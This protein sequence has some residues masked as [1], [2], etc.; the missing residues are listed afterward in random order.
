V[1]LVRSLPQIALLHRREDQSV[2]EN[3]N[4]LP[5]SE[6]ALT[7]RA[8]VMEGR[9]P[10]GDFAAGI[11]KS[12][13]A[14]DGYIAEG[15]P[16]EWIG[17]DPYVIIDPALEWLRNRKKRLAPPKGRGRP[18]GNSSKAKASKKATPALA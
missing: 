13:R 11:G 15:M 16:T 5:Q 7:I 12:K 9:A 1:T 2:S 17:R 10:T 4:S 14:V 6:L 8:K 18:A 3:N